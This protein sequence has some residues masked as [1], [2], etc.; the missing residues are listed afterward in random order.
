MTLQTG[1]LTAA[2]ILGIRRELERE[3]S[4]SQ[5]YHWDLMNKRVP[6]YAADA[7]RWAGE[8][9]EISDTFKGIGLTGNLHKGAA[10]IF[11]LLESS[12]LSEETRETL[13]KSRTLDEAVEIYADTL[14][15]LNKK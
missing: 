8:M 14:R 2:E 7:G 6:F 11:R 10:E 13:D 5:E 1:F 3:L 4:T 9:D 12:P 15:S